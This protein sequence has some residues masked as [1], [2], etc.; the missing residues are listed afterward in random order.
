M[1][2]INTS[3]NDWIKP[4]KDRGIKRITGMHYFLHNTTYDYYWSLTDD[5]ALDLNNLDRLLYYL[6]KNYDSQR[7]DVFIGQSFGNFLQ[8]GV[9][10]IMSRHTAAMV[11]PHSAE[12]ISGMERE[13]DVETDKFRVYAKIKT[14]DTYSPFVYGEEPNIFIEKRF[15]KKNFSECDNKPIPWSPNF[16]LTDLLALHARYV[17]VN[18]ALQNLI[19]AKEEVNNLY[20]RYLRAHIEICKGPI[21]S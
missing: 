1:P 5:V 14:I 11:L 12:W 2:L 7:D 13:D 20:F 4:H 10:F 15:W 21:Y 16:R 3:T 17:D 8:G 6:M 19:H 18:E 9:G